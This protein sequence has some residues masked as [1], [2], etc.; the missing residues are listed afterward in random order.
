MRTRIFLHT[1][2]FCTEFCTQSVD[3]IAQ[4]NLSRVRAVRVTPNHVTGGSLAFAHGQR[5]DWQF[6]CKELE[7][8]HTARGMK[9]DRFKNPVRG[10]Q[11]TEKVLEAESALLKSTNTDTI[12]RAKK[13]RM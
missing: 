8:M 5:D 9:R 6:G 10:R 11:G 2:R 4:S 3:A 7:V 13:W 1:A 12:H